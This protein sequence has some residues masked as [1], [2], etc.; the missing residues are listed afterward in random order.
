MSGFVR[1]EQVL[2]VISVLAQESNMIS[3]HPAYGLFAFESTNVE[4]KGER[5]M[6]HGWKPINIL[7]HFV[8]ELIS[9]KCV[10]MRA[11]S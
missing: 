2:S 6:E 4:E 3:F 5:Q 10:T 9:F 8:L 1:T 11:V 7:I